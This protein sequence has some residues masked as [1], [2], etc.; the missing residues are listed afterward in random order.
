MRLPRR[1]AGSNVERLYNPKAASNSFSTQSPSLRVWGRLTMDTRIRSTAPGPCQH[2]APVADETG[3][4]IL[5]YRGKVPVLAGCTRCQLKFFTPTKLMA[6][7]QTAKDYLWER[8]AAHRC[9]VVSITDTSG[10]FLLTLDE[11]VQRSRRSK[12]G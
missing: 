7:S 3:F 2:F 8:Y 11:Y 6:N 1:R 9:L 5:Q 12:A 10:D 4:A